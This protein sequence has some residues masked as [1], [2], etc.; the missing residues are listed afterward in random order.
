MIA[1]AKTTCKLLSCKFRVKK[2]KLRIYD[3]TCEL[4]TNL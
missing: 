1:W 4:K 2:E 3:K